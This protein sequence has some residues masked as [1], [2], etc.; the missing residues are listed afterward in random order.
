MIA[1]IRGFR[2]GCRGD[3]RQ[4]PHPPAYFHTLPPFLWGWPHLSRLGYP[5]STES[6][7][8]YSLILSRHV[9]LPSSRAYNESGYKEL[10]LLPATKLR[11]DN[12]FRSVCQE[13]C[14]QG[15]S[16]GPHPGGRLGVWR[17]ESPG[18]HP[19]GRLVGLAGGSP[20][21]HLGGVSKPTPRGMGV[22]RPTARGCLQAQAQ[23]CI[24]ACTEADPPAPADGYCCGRYASYSNAFLF[25]DEFGFT[26]VIVF[27]G[28]RWAGDEWLGALRRGGIRDPGGGGRSQRT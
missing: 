25:T 10:F 21:P 13:F 17:R 8:G 4:H 22:F 3:K 24:P 2:L 12:I 9:I 23:G 5:E 6:D 11:Q 19:V 15:G 7:T 1:T 27:V 18:P 14:S 16:P 28:P 20:C 26:D